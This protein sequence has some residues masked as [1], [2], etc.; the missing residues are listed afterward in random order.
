MCLWFL[1]PSILVAIRPARRPLFVLIC[2]SVHVFLSK[3]R[4]T[5]RSVHIKQPLLRVNMNVFF[6]LLV[7]VRWTHSSRSCNSSMS[8]RDSYPGRGG[9]SDRGG[10]S[11]RSRH[12]YPRNSGVGSGCGSGSWEPRGHGAAP[13]TLARK[14]A[15]R[16]AGDRGRP[17]SKG[18]SSEGGGGA[19]G[20]GGSDGLRGVS[21][22][23]NDP[24]GGSTPR[25]CKQLL[26][27]DEAKPAGEQ[28]QH[29]LE[30]SFESL[31]MDEQLA[32]LGVGAPASQQSNDL[33][34]PLW[35]TSDMVRRVLTAPGSPT[36]KEK[37]A[38][39]RVAVERLRLSS[40]DEDEDEDDFEHMDPD[41]YCSGDGKYCLGCPNCKRKKPSD[42]REQKARLWCEAF[43]L[44]LPFCLLFDLGFQ[45]QTKPVRGCCWCPC[46][47]YMKK[48]KDYFALTEEAY[49]CSVQKQGMKT[50]DGLNQHLGELGRS[51]TVHKGIKMYLEELYSPANKASR[52][53]AAEEAAAAAE[54]E[55]QR[56]KEEEEKEAKR[57]KEKAGKEA[58]K[59]KVEAKAAEQGAAAAEAKKQRKK[60]EEEKEA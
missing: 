10:G 47:K 45:D 39:A 16:G 2:P 20:A 33:S 22:G 50:S 32:V 44:A 58:E 23:A 36:A 42:E 49:L 24:Q 5:V 31:T 46:S 15:P 51:C 14:A 8:F 27:M 52:S 29:S 19:P 17:P 13:P 43:L 57:T 48:W 38:A 26:T 55:K 25:S 7:E 34:L 12:S 9:Y 11:G 60:E 3:G 30:S 53:R 59:R 28:K 41:E 40:P 1:C 54:A 18:G 37:K 35:L 6:R 4:V 56:K 21:V